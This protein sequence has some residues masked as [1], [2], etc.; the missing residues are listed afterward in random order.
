MYY[1][2]CAIFSLNGVLL[3]TSII[4]VVSLLENLQRPGGVAEEEN[5]YQLPVIKMRLKAIMSVFGFA[6]I[7]RSVVDLLIGIY[8]AEFVSFAQNYPAL[9]QLAYVIYYPL[10]DMLPICLIFWF[11]HKNF[12]IEED[13]QRQIRIN[14][15]NEDIAMV[16]Q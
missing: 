16:R 12:R 1:Q 2:Q 3:Y 14:V 4:Y 13:D 9:L 5:T 6:N 15:N 7:L 8:L 10:S 11:H